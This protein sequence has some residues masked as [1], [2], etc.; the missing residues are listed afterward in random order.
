MTSFNPTRQAL[1][2]GRTVS[3]LWLESASPEIAELA[4][5]AGWKTILVDNEHGIAS[6]EHTAHLLRAV[7]AAGGDV[8]LRIPAEDPAYLKRIL[9]MGVRSIMVPM[10]NS[11]AQ[12]RAIVDACRYPPQGNRGYAAPIVRASRFGAISD[13][14]RLANDN[15][16]LIV[17][18]EH[19]DAREEI[20]AI[21]AVEGIDMLF[22]GPNDLAGSMDRLE[23]LE[24]A[25]V[26]QTIQALEERITASGCWMGTITA[27][28]RDIDT[29]SNAGY[30][31][32]AGPND[33][34][35][36][37]NALRSEATRW[38]ELSDDFDPG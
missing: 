38:R 20:E 9:D 31:F 23:Q 15:L 25:D 22:I 4:V 17:Q 10:I 16:L 3:A 24:D 32:V 6:L 33:I 13:Y 7:E 14:A 27:P 8:V 36:M 34:A 12:A 35:I 21:A 19:I 28:T 5:H 18:I 29:L 1:E 11:A 26:R 30:R 2:Q 37:A